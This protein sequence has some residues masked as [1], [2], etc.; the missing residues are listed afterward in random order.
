MSEVYHDVGIEPALQ[1]PSGE[2]LS[3]AT[4]NREDEARLDI[5]AGGFWGSRNERTFFDVRIFNPYAPSNKKSSLSSTYGKHEGV[6]KRAYSQRT[7]DVEHGS[8]TLLVFSLTGGL[9]RE[10]DQCYK[11]LASLLSTKWNQPYSVTIGWLR[12]CLSFSFL[13]SSIMRM[14]GTRSSGG[15][16]A[17]YATPV[18]DLVRSESGFQFGPS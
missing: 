5:S 15:F 17:D 13:R 1:S 11:R 2:I 18:M 4:A 8:F 6:K 3:G 10:A 9:G 12:C 16:T 14:R 7:V